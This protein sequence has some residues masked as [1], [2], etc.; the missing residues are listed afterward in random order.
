MSEAGDLIRGMRLA[1]TMSQRELAELAGTRQAAIS[2]IERGLVSPSVETLGRIVA[3]MGERLVLSAEP[4]ATRGAPSRPAG[5]RSSAG[6]GGRRSSP[7][8]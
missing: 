6:S 3:A 5:R 8:G 1:R 4:A 7:A 2:R